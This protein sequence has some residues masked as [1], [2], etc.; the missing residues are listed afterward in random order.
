VVRVHLGLPVELSKEK[1]PLKSES[2]FSR[3]K[4]EI[5]F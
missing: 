4:R 1:N 2:G 5:S 3:A